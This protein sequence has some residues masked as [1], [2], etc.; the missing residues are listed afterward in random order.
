MNQSHV[1]VQQ[2]ELTREEMKDGMAIFA[3]G[4]IIFSIFMWL[5]Y[6]I[7]HPHNVLCQQPYSFLRCDDNIFFNG[8]IF[9]LILGAIMISFWLSFSIVGYCLGY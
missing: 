3:S 5:L 4:F 1:G 9:G 8:G 2:R 7:L 6:K